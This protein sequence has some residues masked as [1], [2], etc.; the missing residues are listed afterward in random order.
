M[1]FVLCVFL[2]M[3]V[4][5]IFSLLSLAKLK[6]AFDLDERLSVVSK[7]LTFNYVGYSNIYTSFLSK[8]GSLGTTFGANITVSSEKAVK[9]YQNQTSLMLNEIFINQMTDAS[10]KALNTPIS[11]RRPQR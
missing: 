2:L 1:Q 6:T 7:S 11:F 8:Q 10:G 5:L 9:L 3:G 4:K